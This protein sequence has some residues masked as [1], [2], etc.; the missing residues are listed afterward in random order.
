[1]IMRRSLGLKLS[2]LSTVILLSACQPDANKSATATQEPL[3]YQPIPEYSHDVIGIQEQYLEPEFWLQRLPNPNE[4]VLT[5]AEIDAFNARSYD[6]QDELVRLNTVPTS[7]SADELRNKIDSISTLPKYPRYYADGT[8]AS[9]EQLQ[10]YRDAVNTAAIVESNPV[11]FGLVVNRTPMRTFPTLDKLYSEGLDL[12]IDRFQETGLFP[13]S[14]VAILHTSADGNWY[15]AQSYNYLAWVQ[16]KDV[17]IGDRD[18]V[19][20]YT[21]QAPYAIVSGGTV[22]TVYNPEVPAVSEVQL[23]MGSRL[24]LMSAT[25]TGHNVHGQNPFA[26]YIVKLPVRNLNGELDFEPALIPRSADMHIGHL[27]YTEAVVISQAFKFLGERYGWGHD[28]NGRDCTGFVSEVYRS[29][30]IDMPRNSGQ[31]GYGE[32]GQTTL[33]DKD[34]TREEKLARIKAAKIGDLMY[35]PGHVVMYIGEINGEP[36]VIHD[37]HG[38]SY[39]DDDGNYYKGTLN[40]VSVTPLLTLGFGKDATYLDAI[41][42][43]KTVR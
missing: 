20:A 9:D 3:N 27:P 4:I 32:Y 38:M 8:Q 16:A 26:T 35:L 40:G 37:V 15:L 1:M 2:V 41:Y 43:I 25:E 6:V 22:R 12:D 39:H 30:G 42:S 19:M 18:V 28:F 10:G 17:A 24:P 7:Y 21:E 23:D 36:Y 13:G 34:A 14:A 33:F 29:V 31:Q 5:P 11:R